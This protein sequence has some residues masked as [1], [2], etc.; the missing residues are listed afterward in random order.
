MKTKK[1]AVKRKMGKEK[2]ID[3][4]YEPKDESPFRS[5][6]DQKSEKEEK[7]LP[8]VEGTMPLEEHHEVVKS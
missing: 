6:R 8:H 5:D 3:R 1:K 7:Q 2:K 4:K